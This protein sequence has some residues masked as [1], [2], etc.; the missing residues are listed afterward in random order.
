LPPM[1]IHC[2]QLVEGA[3]RSALEDKPADPNV[4]SSQQVQRQSPTLMDSLATGEKKVKIKL[5]S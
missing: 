1:K 3:L 2:G 4:A 5:L